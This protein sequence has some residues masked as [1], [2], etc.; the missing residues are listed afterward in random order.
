[1]NRPYAWIAWCCLLPALA[2]AAEPLAELRT[3]LRQPA[4]SPAERGRDLTTALSRPFSLLDMSEAILLTEWRDT[5][6]DEAIAR[7]DQKARELLLRRFEE[8]VQEVL[9]TGAP[10]EK[11]VVVNLVTTLGTRMT[12]GESCRHLGRA[13]GTSLTGFAGEPGPLVG[14]AVC[15]CLATI[16]PSSELFQSVMKVEMKSPDPRRRR[17]AV[18]AA[19]ERC[20]QTEI[21]CRPSPRGCG[22]PLQRQDMLESAVDAAIILSIGGED[23][24]PAVRTAS[25]LGL[26]ALL[27]A[28]QPALFQAEPTG[29]KPLANAEQTV[30]EEL[31]T[32]LASVV[33]ALARFHAGDPLLRIET[34]AELNRFDA[35]IDACVGSKAGPLHEAL[36]GQLISVAPHLGDRDDRVRIAA[37]DFIEGI[38]AAATSCAPVLENALRDAN[39]FVRWSAARALGKIGCSRESAIQALADRLADPEVSV[40]LAS[41]TA[42]GQLGAPARSASAA[43]IT[44]TAEPNPPEVR[45]AAL[46]ALA[47]TGA[48]QEATAQ[49][50]LTRA[51]NDGHPAVREQA[52]AYFQGAARD[53]N[54]TNVL[55]TP[56]AIGDSDPRHALTPPPVREPAAAQLR[57]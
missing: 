45:I 7:V 13:L 20:R 27:R 1:M 25:V 17:A 31:R 15:R 50:A 44:A 22:L 23:S 10:A 14:E 18:A 9:A 43:L 16:E 51:L 30:L 52:V 54:S 28:L 39:P 46:R 42:L 40:R 41:A 47:L 37:S 3:C 34:L 21:R 38:G 12:D 11:L 4:V 35:R 55:L 48:T 24:E 29:Q 5:D 19:V 32:R 56:R 49:A 6:P 53:G 2:S 8:T 36:T 57:P 33:P 26:Q